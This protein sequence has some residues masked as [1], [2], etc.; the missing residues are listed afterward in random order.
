MISSASYGATNFSKILGEITVDEKIP[1][2]WID[3]WK[4]EWESQALAIRTE[5]EAELLRMDIARAEAQA[6]MVVRLIQSLRSV[7][8][9]DADVK[10]YL[11]AARFVD[12]LRWMSFDPFTRGCIPP[13]SMQ[14][15][16]R[17]EEAVTSSR[18][19]P[20]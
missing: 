11:I 10:P 4:T 8:A 18:R 5:G 14:T 12:T 6:D 19:L 3:T 2:Q 9:G 16:K 20:R 15:L 17:I 13:E 1:Q 7:T